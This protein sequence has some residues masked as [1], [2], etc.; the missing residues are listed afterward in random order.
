MHLLVPPASRAEMSN[1]LISQRG[2]EP[3]SPQTPSWP[4]GGPLSVELSTPTDGPTTSG[5]ASAWPSMKPEELIYVS[6]YLG[7]MNSC[8]GILKG[9]S[10]FV[11]AINNKRLNPS[12]VLVGEDRSTSVGSREEKRRDI[13]PSTVVF[14][15]KQFIGLPWVA[16]GVAKDTVRV[17]YNVGNV[18]GFLVIEVTVTEGV[19]EFTAVQI[20]TTIL[21]Q[22]RE[23][24]K[25]K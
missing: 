2:T 5:L 3:L 23:G 4:R 9:D 7:T 11:A 1:Y 17:P 19:E 14:A 24:L 6:F 8:S 13:D 12:V 16:D 15:A 18:D 20:A 10:P 22:L 25:K 21:D